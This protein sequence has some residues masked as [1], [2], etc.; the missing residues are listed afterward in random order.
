MTQLPKVNATR[1]APMGRGEFSREPVGKV[2]LICV[3]LDCGG[4]DDGGAYWGIGEPL[5]HAYDDSLSSDHNAGRGVYRF[6]RAQSRAH[7]KE[8]LRIP[9][10]LYFKSRWDKT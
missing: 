10:A 6:V 5:Y 9:N 7:A 3:T 8:L 1:G 4:Y 2:H